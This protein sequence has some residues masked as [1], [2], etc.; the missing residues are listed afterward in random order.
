[1]P[2]T[3]TS[4][5]RGGGGAL[6]GVVSAVV[7]E[8]LVLLVVA[9]AYVV[10]LVRQGTADLLF[11]VLTVALAVGVAIGL[12]ACARALVRHRRWARAPVITWQLL[13]TAT[14]LPA[15]PALAGSLRAG[16]V[17]LLV[18]AAVAVVGLFTPSVLRATDP[19]GPPAVV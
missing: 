4:A 2:A 5:P 10:L 11:A 17:V 8:A 18:L 1:M 7:V 6:V 12:L 3:P 16:A 13:Q 19:E 9:G 15:L 14:V